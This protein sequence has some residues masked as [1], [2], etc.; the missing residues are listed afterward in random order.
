MPQKLEGIPV[1]TKVTGMFVAYTDPTARFDRPV[2]IGVST[3]HPDIT[4]GTIGCRVRDGQGNV[5]ALSNNHVY[6]N[7]NDAYLGDSA[8]Q[9]GT[10]DGGED[11]VDSIG[12]LIDFEPIDFSVFGSNTMDAAIAIS[13]TTDLDC[14]TP[15]DDGYGIPS[16][17]ITSAY[18]GLG[19]QKYGRTTGL[20][21]GEISEIGVTAAVCYA[22]CNNPI[23]AKYAWFEDQMA[24]ISVNSD[25]FSLGGDSGSLIVTEDGENPVGLLFAGSSTHTLANQIDLVLDR[26]GVTVDDTCTSSELNIPPIAD[27]LFTT[28][29]LTAYFT[30]QSTDPDGSVVAWNWDFGDGSTSTAQNPSHTYAAAGTYSVILTVTDDDAATGYISQNVAVSSTSGE[31]TLTATNYY[32]GFQRVDLE[33][34][35]ATSANVDVYRN[36][37]RLVTTP[38]DGYYTDNLKTRNFSG[39]ITY[40]VCEEG[41]TNCSDEVTVGFQ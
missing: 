30:D 14:S 37:A 5:Y 21:H 41:T 18:V 32:K 12:N 23:F 34:S 3:G 10:Y 4:A 29:E 22:K 16:S 8:L 15:S 27:F 26:F 40:Q 7:Q 24:I 36:D 11:P 35:G 33:W 1:E 25:A 9:P 28:S 20:T 6:A 39:L 19:V 17:E 13:A 38:N 31:I 2:P